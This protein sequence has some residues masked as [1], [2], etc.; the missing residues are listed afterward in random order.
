MKKEITLLGEVYE[1]SARILPNK[2]ALKKGDTEYS[3]AQLEAA[4]IKLKNHLL[5]LG[6]KKGDR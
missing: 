6:L 1:N 4:V 2:L 5:G 3:Y